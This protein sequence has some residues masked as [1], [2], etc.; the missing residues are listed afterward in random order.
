[1][2]VKL[3]K[4]V[5]DGRSR[6]AL[7]DFGPSLLFNE[8]VEEVLRMVKDYY[9]GDMQQRVQRLRDVKINQHS[10]PDFFNAYIKN[11]WWYR[12]VG[13]F[14]V[15]H[16]NQSN[17]TELGYISI[18]PQTYYG[19]KRISAKFFMKDMQNPAKDWDKTASQLDLEG[20]CRYGKKL[21]DSQQ[22]TPLQQR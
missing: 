20:F 9:L 10:K 2:S 1:M 14:E 8:L 5:Y 13:T 11:E 7:L 15:E 3:E 16:G 12:V 4:I 17:E 22:A 18:I 21:I 6:R 19:C